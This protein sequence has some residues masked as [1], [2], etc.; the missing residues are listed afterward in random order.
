VTYFVKM[1]GATDMPMRNHPWP[2]REINEEVRFPPKPAPKDVTK[3]DVLVYYAVGG[4]KR[5]FAVAHVEGQP[6]LNDRHEN[7]VI[8][9]RYPYAAPVSLRPD[10]KLEYVSSGPELSEVGRDLQS[11][12]QHGVSHFEIGKPE[13]DRA[14]ELLRKAKT[15]ETRKLKTGWTP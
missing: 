5:I 7:P 15:E 11:K 1:L 8:A 10:V 9:R 12:V 14:L 6:V 4:Y 2:E 3:G 13:F